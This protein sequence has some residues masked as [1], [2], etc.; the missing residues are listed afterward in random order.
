MVDVSFEEIE[1]A[2]ERRYYNGLPT[3]FY[4]PDETVDRLR[5][6]GRRLLRNSPAYQD[7]VRELR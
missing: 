4:L 2:K 3:S 6:V 5:E 1:D 7:L